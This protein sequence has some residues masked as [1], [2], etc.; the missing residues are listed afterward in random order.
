MLTL[1]RQNKLQYMFSLIKLNLSMQKSPK[2]GLII[3]SNK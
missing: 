3:E 2:K 1:Q